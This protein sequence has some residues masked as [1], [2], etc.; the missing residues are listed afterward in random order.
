[1]DKNVTFSF[2]GMYRICDFSLVIHFDH[3][4]IVNNQYTSS[5]SGKRLDGVENKFWT[6]FYRNLKSLI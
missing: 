3:A 4:L 2:E 6:G 5:F 1:M